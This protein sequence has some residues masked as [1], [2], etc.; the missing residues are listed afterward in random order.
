[1]IILNRTQQG[2]SYGSMYPNK[3]ELQS[4]FKG[5]KGYSKGLG[6]KGTIIRV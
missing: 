3:I 5:S 1:M 4:S 2:T 6:F